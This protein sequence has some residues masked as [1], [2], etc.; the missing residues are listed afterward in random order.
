MKNVKLLQ[1]ETVKI[2]ETIQ[3]GMV[4]QINENE[5]II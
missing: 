5:L 3:N 4:F 2:I 1:E